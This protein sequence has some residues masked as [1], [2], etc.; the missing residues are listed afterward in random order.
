[1]HIAA[2]CF[3]RKLWE[4]S[5]GQRDRHS[6]PIGSCSIISCV[7]KFWYIF[8]FF[9]KWHSFI[10]Q[11]IIFETIIPYFLRDCNYV[12]HTHERKKKIQLKLVDR[13]MNWNSP[14]IAVT[15]HVVAA[16]VSS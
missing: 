6:K 11:R 14:Y 13:K 9:F 10:V 3:Y 5:I 16:E 7:G 1:M 4:K 15:L 2:F 12:N 8:V